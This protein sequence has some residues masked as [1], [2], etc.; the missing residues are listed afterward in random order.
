MDEQHH[1][2]PLLTVGEACQQ[3]RISR[4]SLYRLIQRRQLKTIKIGNRRLIAVAAV[5]HL[6]EQ[7]QEEAE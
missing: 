3:L 1:R 6:I 2:T 4:W 7:L 5:N